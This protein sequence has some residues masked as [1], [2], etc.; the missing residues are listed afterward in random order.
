MKYGIIV[1]GRVTE[2]TEIPDPLPAWANDTQSFLDK[3]FPNLADAAWIQ[4]PDDVVSGAT[5]DGDGSYTNPV[6]STQP[7]QPV[8]FDSADFQ[9]YAYGILG[10]LAVPNG[11][12]DQ[13]MIAGITRYGEILLAGRASVNPATV[14]AFEQYNRAVSFKKEKVQIFLGILNADS[15]IVTDDELEAIIGYWPEV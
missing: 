12:T 7:T 8:T 2:A 6:E 1:N 10:T 14:A 4:I 13:K 15:E 5:D 9:E 3:V 11:T